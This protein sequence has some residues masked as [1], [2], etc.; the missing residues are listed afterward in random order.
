MSTF[1]KFLEAD[2]QVKRKS[3]CYPF[4]ID[5][6]EQLPITVFTCIKTGFNSALEIF[7]LYVVKCYRY[8]YETLSN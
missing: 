1:G 3:T 8:Y 4:R 2:Y 6:F 7:F 5:I